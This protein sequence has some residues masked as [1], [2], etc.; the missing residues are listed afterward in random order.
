[1]YVCKKTFIQRNFPWDQQVAIDVSLNHRVVDR[2]ILSHISNMNFQFLAVLGS[3]GCR[4]K[5]PNYHKYATPHYLGM[6]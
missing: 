1:M 6:N 2:G 5:N 3:P 4:E